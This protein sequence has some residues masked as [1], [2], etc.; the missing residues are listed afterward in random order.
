MISPMSRD[1]TF[2]TD[3]NENGQSAASNLKMVKLLNGLTPAQVEEI[4]N[5]SA[6]HIAGIVDSDHNGK[7]SSAEIDR[8]I[9]DPSLLDSAL[10]NDKGAI[11]AFHT[12]TNLIV[13]QTKN[14][15][16][17]PVEDFNQGQDVLQEKANGA[18]ARF[19]P[20]F[21]V[22]TFLKSEIKTR[23]GAEAGGLDDTGE[24]NLGL[25]SDKVAEVVK[26]FNGTMIELPE[27]QEVCD[28]IHYSSDE[29]TVQPTTQT[30]SAPAKKPSAPLKK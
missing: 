7:I 19:A 18:T 27:R 12:A 5:L 11:G 20:Q 14:A 8:L 6:D 23:L 28:I 15:C 13:A 26:K 2:N 17:G 9:K 25:L 22:A 1:T 30:T 10:G 29:E 16:N 21:L 24:K 3:S 4:S